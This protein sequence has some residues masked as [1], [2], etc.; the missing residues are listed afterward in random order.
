MARPRKR[1][2]QDE[3][4]V[5]RAPLPKGKQSIGIVEERLGYGKSRVRC[6]DGKLRLCR[7]P[8]ARRRDLWIRPG[9]VVLVKPWDIQGDEKGDIVYQYRKAQIAFLRREGHL[10]D[11][12]ASEF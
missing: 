7:I 6:T 3:E 2:E 10:K 1:F 12:E 11:F 4:G 5:V 8:G 9:S